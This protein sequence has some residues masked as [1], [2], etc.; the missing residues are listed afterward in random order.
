MLTL[1]GAISAQAQVNK[2]SL[3][4]Q[5]KVD[6][7]HQKSDCS[8]SGA[9]CKKEAGLPEDPSVLEKKAL[10]HD[11]SVSTN[12]GMLE[13]TEPLG[14]SRQVPK[15]CLTQTIAADPDSGDMFNGAAKAPLLSDSSSKSSLSGALLE[16]KAVHMPEPVASRQNEPEVSE[17][18]S[19][20][21]D[22]CE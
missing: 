11:T 19:L 1:K 17:S 20:M 10:A 8:S 22:V 12:G 7:I 9:G 16:L 3:Q 18:S 4:Q 14:E 15:N 13:G 2:M 5:R 21:N 6:Q